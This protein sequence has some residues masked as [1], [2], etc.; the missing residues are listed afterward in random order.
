V[1][2]FAPLLAGAAVSAPAAEAEAEAAAAAAAGGEQPAAGTTAA[3]APGEQHAAAA[4]SP[5]PGSQSVVNQS[6]SQPASQA[7]RQAG[8]Q[9][10][11][12]S[13]QNPSTDSRSLRTE[14]GRCCLLGFCVAPRYCPPCHTPSMRQ[15]TRTV[16]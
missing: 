13:K 12:Q 4:V 5:S 11:H 9:A 6:A 8:R 14:L 16:P 2:A 10:Q 3:A 1:H 15:D 7:G